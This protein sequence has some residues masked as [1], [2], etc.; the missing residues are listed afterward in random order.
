MRVNSKPQLK[1][2]HKSQLKSEL[3]PQIKAPLGF[4]LIELI[5]VIIILGILSVTV[6]PKFF[7]SNGFEQYTYRNEVVTT[8]RA[9]QLRAMQQ[10]TGNYCHLITV[11]STQVGLRKFDDTQVNNCHLS[12][13]ADKNKPD[14]DKDTSVTIEAKHAVTFSV[15]GLTNTFAFDQLGRVTDFNG[16]RLNCIS[17]NVCQIIITGE[18]ILKIQIENEGYIHAL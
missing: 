17:P 4:T 1:L 10:T 13:F 6:A 11:N 3:K 15:N 8:L 18:E 7:T 14:F 5:V 16:N 12:D 2:Q 9:L